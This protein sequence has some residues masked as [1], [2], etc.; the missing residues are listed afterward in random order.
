M[1]SG[2]KG[3]KQKRKF[4][5][6][7]QKTRLAEIEANLKLLLAKGIVVKKTD[8]SIL[9]TAPRVNELLKKN[10]ALLEILEPLCDLLVKKAAVILIVMIG[11]VDSCTLRS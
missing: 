5:P 7:I 8:A 4:I 9:A 1:A 2:T 6:R 11:N 10:E 3:R